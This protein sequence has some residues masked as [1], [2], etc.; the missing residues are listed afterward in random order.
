ME[1]RDVMFEIKKHIGVISTDREGW[2]KEVNLVSWNGGKTKYDIRSW[3][4]DHEQ[5]TRGIA[6][7]EDEAKAL[8]LAIIEHFAEGEE[9]Q[10]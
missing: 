1:N 3:N 4:A 9:V 10:K 8:V 5:M 6:L 7:T 2:N